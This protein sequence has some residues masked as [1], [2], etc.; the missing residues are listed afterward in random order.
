MP[1]FDAMLVVISLVVGLLLMT[2]GL[3]ELRGRAPARPE[4]RKPP[5]G[6][7]GTAPPRRYPSFY[8]GVANAPPILRHSIDASLAPFA[9]LPIQAPG[10]T[11][12][13]ISG[14]GLVPDRR[15]RIDEW[16]EVHP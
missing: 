4:Q 15:L 8:V 13:D 14:G 7:S 9:S 1:L 10:L 12:V 6:G 16:A 5:Q 2:W 11:V 3:I